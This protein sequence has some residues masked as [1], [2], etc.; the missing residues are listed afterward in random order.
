MALGGAGVFAAVLLAAVWWA[1]GPGRG[2]PFLSMADLPPA[3][4][5]RP[6]D[7]LLLA[8]ATWRGRAVE[9]LSG[10][11]FGHVG[12]VDVD[13]DGVWLVHAS[14]GPDCTVREPLAR[15]LE[16]NRI[17]C[18]R[19]LGVDGDSASAAVALGAAREAAEKAVPFDHR[20]EMGPGTGVYCSELVLDAWAA[21]GVDLLPER[22][23]GKIVY[24]AAFGKSPRCTER[25][26]VSAKDGQENPTM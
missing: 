17:S 14:P 3:E 12:L 2:G 15:Y 22:D 24:P 4:Y 7:I 21:A 8:G 13:R 20:F 1:N 5:F 6:G 11:E 23:R 18:A 19:L 10:A 25:F 9:R 26:A 16:K